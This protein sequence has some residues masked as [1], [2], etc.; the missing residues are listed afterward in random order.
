MSLY[1]FK[2]VMIWSLI[3]YIYIFMPSDMRKVR[4]AETWVFQM[5][6]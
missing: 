5:E 4:K 3:L 2:M 1:V 6:F